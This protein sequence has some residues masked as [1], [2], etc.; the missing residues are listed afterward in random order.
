MNKKYEVLRQEHGSV[1][2]RPIKKNRTHRQSFGSSLI[3]DF[4]VFLDSDPVSVP[5]SQAKKYADCRSA[6]K[7]CLLKKL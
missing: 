2:S 5:V 4:Q 6:W 7:R 1:T 3:L